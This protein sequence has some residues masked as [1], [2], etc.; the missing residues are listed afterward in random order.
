M[1]A[2][3]CEVVVATGDGDGCFDVVGVGLNDLRGGES[4]VILK[5]KGHRLDWSMI[6]ALLPNYY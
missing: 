2:A 5:W 4:W 1:A 6:D 3:V